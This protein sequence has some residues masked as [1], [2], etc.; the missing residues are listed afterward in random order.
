MRSILLTTVAAAAL[1]ALPFQAWAQDR[2][3]STQRPSQMSESPRSPESQQKGMQGERSGMQGERSGSSAAESSRSPMSQQKDMQAERPGRSATEPSQSGAEVHGKSQNRSAQEELKS[4]SSREARPAQG[5]ENQNNEKGSMHKPSASTEQPGQAKKQ[6][7]GEANPAATENERQPRHTMRSNAPDTA[8]QQNKTQ[9]PE[10]S[11]TGGNQTPNK[12]TTGGSAAGGKAMPEQ[13]QGAAGRSETGG[14]AMPA[15]GKEQRQG[16]A[17]NL[18]PQ[19]ETRVVTA[20]RNESVQRL[21]RVDFAL[22][23]GTVIPTFVALNPLPE[24]IIE[25]VPQYRGFDFVMVRDEIII[26]EPRTRRIVT[27]LRGEG[28][29]AATAA[30]RHSATAAHHLQLTREQRRLIRRDLL[31]GDSE[32]VRLDS[33]EIG[34]RVPEDISLLS[35]PADVL[36]EVPMIR[37]YRYVVASNEV[38]FV[39]PDTREIVDVID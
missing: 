13:R 11:T 32:N 12:A 20:L 24:S 16:A 17:V 34:E 29:S 14:S 18:N 31:T 5:A 15:Q 3:P 23:V 2:N 26:I 9:R 33:V 22:T 36:D 27:V 35:I 8:E 21:D 37:Q 7:Q 25:I 39:A 19:Q 28:R 1:A 6:R 10:G 30:H 38:V 4:K